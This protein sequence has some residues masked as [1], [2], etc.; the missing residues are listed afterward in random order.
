MTTYIIITERTVH[1]E[2]D[3]R[4]QRY[5]GHGYPAYTETVQE[6]TEFTDYNAF[7]DKIRELEKINAEYKAYSA[8]QLTVTTTVTVNVSSNC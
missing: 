3:E 2:G 7:V 4:S 6:A 1:H 8:E 5:P